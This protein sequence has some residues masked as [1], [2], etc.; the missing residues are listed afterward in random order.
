MESIFTNFVPETFLETVLW[1]MRAYRSHGFTEIYWAVEL[2]TFI[3]VLKSSLSDKSFKEIEPFYKW[4]V[5]NIP[6]F[7]EINKQDA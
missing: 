5:T 4:I 6:I 2:D 1:A 7:L 3:K